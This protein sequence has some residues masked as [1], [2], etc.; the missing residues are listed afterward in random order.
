[1][2]Y[3]MV[4]MDGAADE[5]LE[6]LNGQTVL[7]KADIPNTDWIS[8]NGRQGMVQTVPPGM[9]PGSDVAIMSVLGYDPAKCYPGRAPLEAVAQGIETAPSD[10]IFR[11]NLVTVAD[12]VMR[13]HS[14]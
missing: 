11:C 12:G 3:A 8:R 13:D 4:I 6:E 7:E 14:A 9:P 1:M 5:P 10:W 2:K